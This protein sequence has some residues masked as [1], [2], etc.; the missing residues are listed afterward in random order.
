LRKSIQVL[1]W[2]NGLSV[3]AYVIFFLGIIYLDLTVFPQWEV[4]SQPPQAV[5]NLI[6]ASSD[7]SGLRDVALLLY[8]HLTDQTTVINQMIDSIIF[9]VRIHFLLSLCLFSANLF[10]IFKLRKST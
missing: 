9:W 7:Q 8:E 3:L 5:L 1:L 6:Q 10:L 2:I 4:L